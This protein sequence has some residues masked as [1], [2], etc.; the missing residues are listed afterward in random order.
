MVIR[1]NPQGLVTMVLGRKDESI[2]Y[3][4]RFLE[5]ARHSDAAAI[6]TVGAG[7]GRGG[8]FNRPTDVTWD[9]DGNIFISDCYNNSRVAKFTKDGDFVKSI[10]SLGPWPGQFNKPHTIASEANGNIYVVDRGIT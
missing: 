9:N 1:F 6:T 5:E 8:T 4:E 3:L 2:D 7:G 10:G